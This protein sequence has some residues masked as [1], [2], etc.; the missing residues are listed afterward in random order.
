MQEKTIRCLLDV[1][2]S[3]INPDIAKVLKEQK[4]IDQ[5]EQIRSSVIINPD[6][7]NEVEAQLEISGYKSDA[8]SK[9][10]NSKMAAS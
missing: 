9:T 10:N 4:E 8:N 5:H 3:G 7:I 2:M 1:S 6:Q